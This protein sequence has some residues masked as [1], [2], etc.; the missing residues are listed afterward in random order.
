MTWPSLFSSRNGGNTVGNWNVFIIF[1][2]A[3]NVGFVENY[4]VKS[5]KIGLV[6]TLDQ[7]L[8]RSDLKL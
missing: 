3:Y 4:A 1:G 8:G 5:I 6:E 2:H 7:L